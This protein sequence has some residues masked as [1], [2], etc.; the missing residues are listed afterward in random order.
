[1]KCKKRS[2][3]SDYVKVIKVITA[4]WKPFSALAV[5]TTARTFNVSA[6][7]RIGL[8]SVVIRAVQKCSLVFKENAC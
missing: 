4:M 7:D 1:M 5:P 6:A 2:D 8:Y 3:N